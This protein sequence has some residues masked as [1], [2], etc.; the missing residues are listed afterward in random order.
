ME[1]YTLDSYFSI[2]GG[3]LQGEPIFFLQSLQAEIKKN[4]V[5]KQA[6]LKPDNKE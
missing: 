4:L 3:N 2:G 6:A 5:S 1:K